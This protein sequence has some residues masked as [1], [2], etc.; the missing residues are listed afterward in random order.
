ME[1]KKAITKEDQYVQSYRKRKDSLLKET[2]QPSLEI[3]DPNV[4][5]GV[6][7]LKIL[8]LNRIFLLH[9]VI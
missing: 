5:V 3:F 2:L 9:M 6:M 1:K 4:G 7:L 8:T